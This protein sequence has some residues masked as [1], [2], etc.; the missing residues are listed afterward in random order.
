[1]DDY[2][3]CLW[4][5]QHED[6]MFPQEMH[7]STKGYFWDPV[8]HYRRYWKSQLEDNSHSLGRTHDLGRCA[9]NPEIDPL[10][11]LFAM[12]DSEKFRWYLQETKQPYQFIPHSRELV[13]LWKNDPAGREDELWKMH[14]A[15]YER[16]AYEDGAYQLLSSRTRTS[17]SAA[18]AATS[19]NSVPVMT[20]QPVVRSMPSDDEGGECV[21]R[22]PSVFATH[23][24]SSNLP[25]FQ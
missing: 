11:I 17:S 25:S 20:S 15:R 12:S 4:C 16:F 18:A 21:T 6:V 10:K 2:P 1:M 23:P 13:D 5:V 8:E 7:K 22:T 9:Q 24:T 19:T 14:I 3:D